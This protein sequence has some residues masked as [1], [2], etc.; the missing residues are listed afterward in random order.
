MIHMA[1]GDVDGGEVAM[2]QGNP[3]AQRFGLGNRGQRIHQHG[4]VLTEDQGC[5]DRVP[6]QGRPERRRPLTHDRLLRRG[7][8]IHTQVR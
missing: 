8:D 5:R 4:V 7:E 2:V 6:R 1:V 3:A